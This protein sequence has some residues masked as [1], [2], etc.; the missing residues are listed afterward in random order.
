MADTNK[1]KKLERLLK[2]IEG[3]S[4]P[5]KM[6]LA[7]YASIVLFKKH[8][9]PASPDDFE[10][11]WMAGIKAHKAACGADFLEH[12]INVFAL[13]GRTN[14]SLGE[15]ASIALA[16]AAESHKIALAFEA[17]MQKHGS[18]ELKKMAEK[19]GAA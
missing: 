3:K 5:A 4:Q 19:G 16:C 14:I 1:D 7:L 6:S 2:D 11:V 9:I 18:E 10:K 15:L 8:N 17:A 13:K 12:I